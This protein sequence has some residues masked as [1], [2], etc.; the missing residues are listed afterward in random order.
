MRAVITF[1][2]I[3][4]ERGPLSFSPEDLHA[5]LAA[6]AEA[7][8]PVLDLDTLLAGE[9]V[10]GVALT[11][12]DGM[13]SLHDEALPIL[14]AF[15][16]P[17]HVFVVTNRLG[18]NNRWAGQPDHARTYAML[19]WHQ[20]ERLHACGVRV[21]GHTA[22]HP[23]L[24]SLDEA[25]AGAEFDEADAVIAARLGR[26][27][28]YVAYPYGYHN[29]LV[30]AVAG[31]RYAGCFTTKLGYLGEQPDSTALPRLDSHYLRSPRLVRTLA[32]PAVRGYMGLRGMLRRWR[33]TE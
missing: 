33:G 20:V 9:A 15:G 28:R 12:D 10:R 32:H 31:R 29:D 23:D 7:R 11:F 19:D 18:A 30:R 4:R 16:T 1:H 21:E 17:A 25:A 24:R 14:R 27:P 6:L 26:R 3:D 13:R 8:I 5:L 22:N 2:A